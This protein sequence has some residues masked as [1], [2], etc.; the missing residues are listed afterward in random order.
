MRYHAKDY[1]VHNIF[2]S[3]VLANQD[4]ESESGLSF[5]ISFSCDVVVKKNGIPYMTWA[6]QSGKATAALGSYSGD[7][8]A[9][10][11]AFFIAHRTLF[12]SA[13]R[14][15]GYTKGDLEDEYL[16]WHNQAKRGVA[17]P[18][19]EELLETQQKVGRATQ[20][21]IRR[22][23]FIEGNSRKFW[24]IQRLASPAAR[25]FIVCWGKIPAD[26]EYLQVEHGRGQVQTKTFSKAAQCKVAW[27]RLIR[28]N[29]QKG[30][31]E[32]GHHFV[33]RGPPT[34]M[35]NSSPSPFPGI[36]RDG[37][38]RKGVTTYRSET[39]TIQGILAAYPHIDVYEAKSLTPAIIITDWETS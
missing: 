38:N 26:D 2:E 36:S 18:S 11:K 10:M 34:E 16:R 37:P 30:Y 21:E 17:G 22:F 13:L 9:F 20:D 33:H 4:M 29:H 28:E 19:E 25:T 27:E 24:T 8:V 1:D 23:Q 6:L 5:P 7:D 14:K 32:V 12:G 39:G 15:A 31:R 3:I 35:E